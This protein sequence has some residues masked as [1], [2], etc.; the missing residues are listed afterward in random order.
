MMR[1]FHVFQQPVFVLLA[2]GCLFVAA[3]KPLLA[4][5]GQNKRT[6]EKP[7]VILIMAD[8]MGYECVGCYGSATYKT[9]HLDRLAASGIRFEHCHSQPLCTPTRVKLMTGKYNFRNYDE[10]DY[11]SPKDTTIGHLMKQAGYQT[12]IAGKWQLNGI[13]YNYPENQDGTRP[14]KA[15]FDR[16]CLW[17]VTKSRAVGRRY[18]DPVLEKDGVVQPRY[19]GEYGPQ[20]CADFVCDFIEENQQKAFFVYYPMILPHSPYVPTPDSPE[21]KEKNRYQKKDRFFVDMVQYVDKIVGQ[22]DAKLAELGIRENT[23]LMFTGDNGTGR[24][25]KSKMRDGSVV[26]GAK[27]T[28]PD[29]G[30]HVPFIVSWPAVVKVGRVNPELVGFTDFYA[31]LAELVHAPESSSQCDGLSLL[32][33]LFQTRGATREHIYCHYDSRWGGTAKYRARF[34][35]DQ[36]YKLY[37]NG[38]FFNVA[39]DPLEKSPIEANTAELAQIRKAFQGVLDSYP[40]L[41]TRPRRPVNHSKGSITPL[42]GE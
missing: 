7:N 37:H 25:V 14:L 11:L 15:G 26:L 2:L 30:H 4:E 35:Y 8:D 40:E 18:A 16:S 22:I 32:P 5:G 27:G 3:S 13:T 20:I 28:T 1:R 21:W 36:N 24:G 41:D 31:T 9:P 29:T 19:K 33:Q 6:Q 23:L 17:Q 12:C 39:N 42:P 10:F 38:Q 34:V